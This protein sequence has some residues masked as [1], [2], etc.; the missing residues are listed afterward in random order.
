MSDMHPFTAIMRE[1]YAA[2]EAIIRLFPDSSSDE[3]DAFQ[4]DLPHGERWIVHAQRGDVSVLRVIH[5]RSGRLVACAW[6]T[7]GRCIAPA[8]WK[9]WGCCTSPCK[10]RLAPGLEAQSK[11]LPDLPRNDGDCSRLSNCGRGKSPVAEQQHG[12]CMSP[13]VW[14]VVCVVLLHRIIAAYII[15]LCVFVWRLTY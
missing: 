13:L 7:P 4:V 5:T 3:C 15:N 2:S 8:N 10:P 12:C 1:E 14:C 11:F 6:W 9:G